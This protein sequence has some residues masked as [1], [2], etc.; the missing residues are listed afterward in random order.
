MLEIKYLKVHWLNQAETEIKQFLIILKVPF[1]ESQV[2]IGD[3]A[4]I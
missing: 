4:E 1:L 2:K 3:H